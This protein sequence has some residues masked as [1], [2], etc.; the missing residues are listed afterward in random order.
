[1]RVVVR[2]TEMPFFLANGEV[3]K[4]ARPILHTRSDKRRPGLI[5]F[6]CVCREEEEDGHVQTG[7]TK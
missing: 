7:R 5:A 2:N 4:T 1:M 6:R 3:A